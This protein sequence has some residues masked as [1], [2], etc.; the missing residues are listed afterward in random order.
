MSEAK[1]DRQLEDQ[2]DDQL[3]QEQTD[4]KFHN[5]LYAHTIFS[6]TSVEFRRKVCEECS[7]STPT[8]YRKLKALYEEKPG[9]TLSNAEVEMIQGIARQV[10]ENLRRVLDRVKSNY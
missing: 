4:S 1:D 6:K 5:L 8:F 2:Q 9:G 7:W 3:H 10:I